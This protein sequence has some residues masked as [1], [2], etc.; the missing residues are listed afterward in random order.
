MRID[1][2]DAHG[3]ERRRWR[4]LP[5][6]QLLGQ[7]L[8][9]VLGEPEFEDP[10]ALLLLQIAGADELEHVDSVQGLGQLSRER[11]PTGVVDPRAREDGQ[12]LCPPRGPE[13]LRDRLPRKA[14]DTAFTKQMQA[15]GGK[16]LIS[17]TT[18]YPGTMFAEK[19]DELGLHILTDNW[20]VF[21]AKHIVMETRY[22]SAERIKVIATEMAI[23]LGMTRSVD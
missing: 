8:L 17:Y 4:G 19:A 21:D 5:S 16:L 3:R 23:E 10:P 7:L 20:T 13:K 11:D 1:C 14:R 9:G 15:A 2:E 18:P 12:G 6:G 22:L